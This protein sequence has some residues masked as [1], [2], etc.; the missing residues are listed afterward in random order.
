VGAALLVT[1]GRAFAE[2]YPIGSEQAL[3]LESSKALP[4]R[5]PADVR[6]VLVADPDVVDALIKTPRL[7]YLVGTKIGHTNAFFLDAAG[8][9]ILKLNIVVERDLTALRNA[10]A[11]LTPNADIKV[12]TL[13]DDIILSGSAPS[14][15]A[16]EQ[17][18]QLARRFVKADENVVNMVDIS[19]EQQVVIRVHVAEMRREVAKNL[20]VSLFYQNDAMSMFTM[21]APDQT[22]FEKRS[23]GFT[24]LGHNQG[25]AYKDGYSTA[26]GAGGLGAMGM[27]PLEDVTSLSLINRFVGTIEALESEGLVKTLAEPNLTAVSGEVANFLVGGEFPLIKG[28]NR[29]TGMLAIEFKPFGVLLE[30]RPVV[31]SSGLINMRVRTEVSQL[32]DEGS[33]QLAGFD[34]PGVTVRRAETTVETPSGG[35]LVLAGMLREEV[36]DTLR[37][38][39][40]LRHIP[41]LGALFQSNEFLRSETELVII[42]TPYLVR[43]APR[44]KLTLPT[45]GFAMANDLD[46]YLA[47]GF[48]SR[49]GVKMGGEGKAPDG[50]RV[51]YII[52]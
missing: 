2:S 41:I 7:I 24:T 20:G 27:N 51:G 4:I 17:A 35:S 39:P 8:N 36:R 44:N 21:Q 38:L 32:S 49:Y 26:S 9:Q 16:N 1:G 22:L 23:G 14:A 50:Q 40:G 3:T 28:Y 18:R 46:L 47:N 19:G 31:L 29:D 37:A 34:V 45:D 6:D 15:T 13:A 5:L 30:F 11:T 33:I 43:P 48:Y 12:R 42:A 52:R 25:V 10:L